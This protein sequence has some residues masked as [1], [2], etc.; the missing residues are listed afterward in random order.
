MLSG[1]TVKIFRARGRRRTSPNKCMRAINDI[2]K[3][4]AGWF[5]DYWWP[6]TVF[7][8]I[9]LGISGDVHRCILVKKAFTCCRA[10]RSCP[11]IGGG[12]AFRVERPPPACHFCSASAP[13]TTAAA[14][15][16]AADS[17]SQQSCHNVERPSSAEQEPASEQ[18]LRQLPG[19]VRPF[20]PVRR[21]LCARAPLGDQV[22]SPFIVGGSAPAPTAYWNGI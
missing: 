22:V 20:R 5:N 12:V 8:T 18:E 17:T 19:V 15:P 2:K 21:G 4:G 10:R 7:D 3:Q 1:C 11:A 6:G 9:W 14:E 16:S 13:T